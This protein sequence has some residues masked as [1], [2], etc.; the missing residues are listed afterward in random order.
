METC[1]LTQVSAPTASVAQ[2]KAVKGSSA[3]CFAVNHGTFPHICVVFFAL[4]VE[5]W[6][7]ASTETTSNRNS[8]LYMVFIVPAPLVARQPHTCVAFSTGKD[9]YSK[10]TKLRRY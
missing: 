8:A 3:Q 5:I 2:D 4:L 9:Q 7:F 10:D 6:M 1:A